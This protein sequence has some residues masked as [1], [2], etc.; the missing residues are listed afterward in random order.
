MGS[1]IRKNHLLS[2]LLLS[3]P[4]RLLQNKIKIVRS[5]ISGRY[6]DCKGRPQLRGPRESN[7]IAYLPPPSACP[8][9]SSSPRERCIEQE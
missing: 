1:Q 8:V 3:Y 4:I 2:L 6:R 7:T 5:V 9:H